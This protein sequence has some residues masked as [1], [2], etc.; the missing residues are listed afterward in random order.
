MI[1]LKHGGAG[2]AQYVELISPTHSHDAMKDK[3]NKNNFMA[4]LNELKKGQANLEMA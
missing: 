3:Y 1:A 2:H 4:Q